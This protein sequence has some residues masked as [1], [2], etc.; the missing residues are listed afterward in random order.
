MAMQEYRCHGCGQVF[1]L[2]EIP[3]EPMPEPLECPAC[4]SQ[5]VEHLATVA[6][7]GALRSELPP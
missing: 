5:K 2:V 1:Q 3:D 7:A 4:H 6:G